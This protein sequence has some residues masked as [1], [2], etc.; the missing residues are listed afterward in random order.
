MYD[1]FVFPDAEGRCDDFAIVN[2]CS[3][4]ALASVAKCGERAR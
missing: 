1:P 4:R 2:R 3:P